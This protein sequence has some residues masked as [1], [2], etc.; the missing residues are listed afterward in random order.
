MKFRVISSALLMLVGIGAPAAWAQAQAASS[1]ELYHVRF[2]KAVPGQLAALI[3]AELKA[4]QDPDNPEP[5]I[6]LRHA[7]G[8]DWQLLV[9]APLGKDET[10]RAEQPNQT[11]QQFLT[12]LRSLSM[13]HDDTIVQ[14]PPWAEAK[15]VLVGD[16]QPGAVYLI[17]TFESVPGHRDQL[18]S[19]L[20]E[21]PVPSAT[22]VLTHREGAPWTFLVIERYPSWTALG[23]S[24]QKQ[25]AGGPTSASEHFSAHHDTIVTRVTATP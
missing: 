7:Q 12:Q 2:V 6:I 11:L 22:L 13:R 18:L 21:S 15:K 25:A 24:M 8:D 10:I 3:A 4:P 5:P 1:E 23:E 9:I 14:G 17:G 20:K 19:A 16:G